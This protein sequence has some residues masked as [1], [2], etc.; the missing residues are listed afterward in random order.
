[1]IFSWR[2]T[3]PDI[4]YYF[5]W[6]AADDPATATG[7]PPR[8]LRRG[9]AGD[10]H[11]QLPSLGRA[12][13]GV[14]G[15][16]R[17]ACDL[18]QRRL[19]HGLPGGLPVPAAEGPA[20]RPG[21]CPGRRGDTEQYALQNRDLFERFSPRAVFPMHA[22]AGAR[23]YREFAAAFG[24]RIPASDHGSGE[25][26]RPLRVSRRADQQERVVRHPAPPERSGSRRL[27]WRAPVSSSPCAALRSSLRPRRQPP[28]ALSLA[29]RLRVR[30][31]AR[32]GGGARRVAG[33]QSVRNSC[34]PLRRGAHRSAAASE[35]AAGVLADAGAPGRLVAKGR[36]PAVAGNSTREIGG[37]R[38]ATVIAT[39]AQPVERTMLAV[40]EEVFHVFW[41][42]RHPSFR[43]NEMARYAYPLTMRRTSVACSPK[44]KRSRGRSRRSA[45]TTRPAGRPPRSRSAGNGSRGWRKTFAPSRRR[46]K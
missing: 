35:P 33:V 7:R 16:G 20:G 41:L 29:R 30:S 39:P 10:C 13:G 42:A 22:E 31:R 32:R 23:M 37:V 34:C 26:G 5:G 12:G 19:P 2:K 11:H 9:R 14:S 40:V 46:S 44:T 18:P 4:A 8:D 24:A 43:P 1:M 36:H 25:T 45:L 27:S 38:T 17:R 6:K 3:V 15:E 28:A 21:L